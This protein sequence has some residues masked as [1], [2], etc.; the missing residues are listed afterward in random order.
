M[1]YTITPK[2]QIYEK[3]YLDIY[4]NISIFSRTSTGEINQISRLFVGISSEIELIFI[5]NIILDITRMSACVP[6]AN[7]L[8]NKPPK[9]ISE[10]CL[11]DTVTFRA[12]NGNPNM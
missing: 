10:V 9:Y 5:I 4:R 8:E 2:P 6:A 11:D 7:M 12:S 3:R 1:R